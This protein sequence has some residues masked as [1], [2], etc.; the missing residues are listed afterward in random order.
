[1]AKEMSAKK[2]EETLDILIGEVALSRRKIETIIELL[3]EKGLLA[4]AEFKNKLKENTEAEKL[5]LLES[6]AKK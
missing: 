1:M 4:Y 6:I 5:E 3:D 2:I